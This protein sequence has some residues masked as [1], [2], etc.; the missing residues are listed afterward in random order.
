MKSGIGIKAD[1]TYVIG[2]EEVRLL[3]GP[4]NFAPKG[5]AD[6]LATGQHSQKQELFL[7]T[8]PVMSMSR[9]FAEQH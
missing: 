9:Q 1:H 6:L 5:K 8:Q 4:A 3:V 2:R 7:A